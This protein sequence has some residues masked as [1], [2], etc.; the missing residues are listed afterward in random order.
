MTYYNMVI[1]AI[2]VLLCIVTLKFVW[3]ILSSRNVSE[4]EAAVTSMALICAVVVVTWS[5]AS[6]I[7]AEAPE[8]RMETKYING[9]TYRIH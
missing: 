7:A 8:S 1:I 6:V 5:S 3:I 9:R 4:V 2:L